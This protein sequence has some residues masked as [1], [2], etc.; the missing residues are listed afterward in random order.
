MAISAEAASGVDDP[1]A[2]AAVLR[3]RAVAAVGGA[4]TFAVIHR[5]E[6]AAAAEAAAALAEALDGAAVI[7]ATS[8]RGIMT[9]RGL[10][11][12]GEPA[13]G[14]LAVRD[15]HGA[16][17]SAAEPFASAEP[18][19]AATAA[20]RAAERAL[21]AADR[22]GETPV[23]G[24]VHATPGFE[25]A[26]LAGVAE[27]F[28]PTTPVTGGSAADEAVAGRWAVQAGAA[29]LS[30]GV[31][32]AALFPSGRAAHSFQCGYA[33][34]GPRGVVT[35]ARRRVI[36]EID[37]APA[38]HV[39]N[40]WTGGAIDAA[41]AAPAGD[42]ARN[43]L[44]V[45]TLTPLAVAVGA[46]KTDGAPAQPYHRLIHP[47]RVTDEGGVANFAHVAEGETIELMTGGMEPLIARGGLAA[48]D[49]LA[50][51]DLSVDAIAGGLSVFCGGCMLALGGDGVRAAQRRI[52]TDLGE[53]PFLGVFT[54]GEQGQFI[55]GETRH[56]N[57]MVSHL[58]FEDAA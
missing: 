38:A 26:V 45:T 1:A 12:F 18:E 14:L 41:L 36:L 49:A 57:L 13:V 30:D 20:R 44:G 52:A 51:A 48:R 6:H 25:E 53:R 7:G 40:G 23:V 9:H 33:A 35:K 43:V 15:P 11:G 21:A 54:F 37:G 42:G 47:E 46:I 4:P 17:G 55:N 39:Y 2:V 50:A 22:V 16:F 27:I 19:A 56:G 58:L 3:A 31:A 5:T 8:C 28:G 34:A 29:Q 32:V 24:W 10:F